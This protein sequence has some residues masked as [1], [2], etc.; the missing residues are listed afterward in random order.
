M[1]K[2]VLTGGPC[3][4]K[5]TVLQ[6]LKQRY[7]NKVMV[8]PEA[9]TML[10]GSGFPMPGRDLPWSPAWQECLQK[11]ICS[12]Q[13][14]LE[15]ACMLAARENGAEILVCDRGLLDGAAYTEGGLPAFQEKFGLDTA[16]AHAR[17]ARIVHLESV[18]VC[19]PHLYGTA[20]N[21][22]RFESVEEAAALDAKTRAAWQGHPAWQQVSGAGGMDRVVENVFRLVDAMLAKPVKRPVQGFP[23]P[24]LRA[25]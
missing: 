24:T 20:S 23:I 10:M 22:V 16:A 15:D 17:Y 12:L 11:A 3:A 5:S 8:V 6:A 25:A 2:I 14:A 1:Q 7:G 4:G 19:A 13:C 9:A 18:A 21:Q